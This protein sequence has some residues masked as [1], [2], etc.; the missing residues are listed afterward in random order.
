MYDPEKNRETN[1]RRKLARRGYA[2]RK[3]KTAKDCDGYMIVD[4]KSNAVAAGGQ[5]DL[6]ID[7]VEQFIEDCKQ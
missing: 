2:L 6:S 7:E 4:I 3:S 5:H 1:A